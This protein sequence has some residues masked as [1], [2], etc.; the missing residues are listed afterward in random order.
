VI[1]DR[2]DP[3]GPPLGQGIMYEIHA[4]AFSRTGRDRGRTTMQRDM[5]STPDPHSQ[6]QAVQSLEPSHPFPIHTPAFATQ[7]HPNAQEPESRARM[8]QISNTY[9]QGGLILRMASS[10]P[11]RPPKLRQA[12]GPQATDLK[13]A[14]KPGGQ[15]STACGP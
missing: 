8:G 2:Q 10:I 6:L 9:P 11:R 1:D 3:E 4:P 14:V 13:R 15:F 12:A 5:L 7:E